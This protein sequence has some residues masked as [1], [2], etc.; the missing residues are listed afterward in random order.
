MLHR[1]LMRK[2]GNKLIEDT[3]KCLNILQPYIYHLNGELNHV[4]LKEFVFGNADYVQV[5]AKEVCEV[6]QIFQA[7]DMKLLDLGPSI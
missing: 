4:H 6:R 1:V 2:Y 5:V 3:E 7:Y